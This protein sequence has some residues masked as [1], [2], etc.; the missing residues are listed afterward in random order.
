MNPIPPNLINLIEYLNKDLNDLP[1]WEI[2]LIGNAKSSVQYRIRDHFEASA[3]T[4]QKFVSM[5]KEIWQEEGT[6]LFPLV[7]KPRKILGYL[8]KQELTR[9]ND[10][11][12]LP[13]KTEREDLRAKLHDMLDKMRASDSDRDELTEIFERESCFFQDL[14]DHVKEIEK[15]TPI[16]DAKIPIIAELEQREEFLEEIEEFESKATGDKDRYKKATSLAL[17][18]ENKFRAYAAKKMK[19]LD[20]RAEKLCLEFEKETGREFQI[21]GIR[22][23]DMITEQKFGRAS[24]PALSLAKLKISA[25]SS[26]EKKRYEE[27]LAKHDSK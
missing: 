7:E 23:L 18:E 4:R 16:Y 11:V 12:L 19:E 9:L 15:W 3:M 27:E 22:Y 17:E 21:D 1:N 2:T 5:P 10:L 20:T 25:I 14:E 24:N 6:G 8:P 13:L 26:Y